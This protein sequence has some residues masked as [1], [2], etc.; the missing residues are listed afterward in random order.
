[1]LVEQGFGLGHA[2]D[3]A[4]EHHLDGGILAGLEGVFKVL[5]VL[6]VRLVGAHP[7][8]DAGVEVFEVLDDQGTAGVF[9]VGV[10]EVKGED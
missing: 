2:V 10:G 1:M 9:A 7:A 6:D 3:G 5:D 4:A 8:T